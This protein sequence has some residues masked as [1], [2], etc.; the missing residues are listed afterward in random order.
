MAN[1]YTTTITA[2][3]TTGSD[4]TVFASRGNTIVRD[5]HIYAKGGAATVSVKYDDGTTNAVIAKKSLAAD[6]KW[7][8]FAAP[9]APLLNHELKVNTSATLNILITYV[10]F[11]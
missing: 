9:I 4:V 10:E 11:D 2:V 6:E 1:S 7:H 8:P 5:M 3:D